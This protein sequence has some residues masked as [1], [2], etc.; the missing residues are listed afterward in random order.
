MDKGGHPR[1]NLRGAGRK[2]KTH[3]VF[4]FVK[5]KQKPP[6][7]IRARNTQKK[8]SAIK[9]ASINARGK[10]S[11]INWGIIENKAIL[12]D[13]VSV[14]KRRKLSAGRIASMYQIPKSTVQKEL[15]GKRDSVSGML[16]EI[17]SCNFMF[18][19]MLN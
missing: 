9:S 2:L 1:K 8:C 18:N 6:R 3:D 16:N 7:F 5:L 12:Q 13:A 15:W 10:N 19:H 11:R 17:S 4:S 14:M